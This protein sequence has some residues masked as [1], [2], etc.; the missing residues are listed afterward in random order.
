MEYHLIFRHLSSFIQQVKIEVPGM[1]EICGFSSF[2]LDRFKDE[3]YD[4][5]DDTIQHTPNYPKAQLGKVSN[6]FINFTLAYPSW[7]CS[8]TS[9]DLLDRINCLRKEQ[10]DATRAEQLHHLEVVQRQLETLQFM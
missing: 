1:G 3:T 6:S 5:M 8:Y 7:R 9:Q 10:A 4:D 2:D